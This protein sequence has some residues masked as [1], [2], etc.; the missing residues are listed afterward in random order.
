MSV[1]EI[2]YRPRRFW[3]ALCAAPAAWELEAAR[4]WLNP[5]QMALFEQMQP[6]EQA[7]SLSGDERLWWL[8]NSRSGGRRWLLKL[9]LH[10]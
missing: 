10:L 6:V 7:H 8:A 3:S 1:A 9:A 2:M 5:A 4:H